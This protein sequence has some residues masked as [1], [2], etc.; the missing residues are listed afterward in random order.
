[1]AFDWQPLSDKQLQVINPDN[2][3]RLNFLDGAVR[4]GKTVAELLAWSAFVSTYAPPGKLA[5]IGKTERTLRRNLLDP[6]LDMFG[7]S[8]VQVNGGEGTALLFGRQVDLYGAN[9][10]KAEGK[11]RGAT[12]AGV[13]CDEV[14]L[15]PEKVF[16]TITSRLSVPGSRLFATLNPDS[17]YHYLYV[18]YL[19]NPKLFGQ[20]RRWRFLLDDNLALSDEFKESIRREHQGLFYDRFV[21]GLWS[22]AEGAIYGSIFNDAL[23]VVDTPAPIHTL[24][25][26]MDYG[27]DNP[28][29][30]LLLG[31]GKDDCIYVLDE[32]YYGTSMDEGRGRPKVQT[33]L[34]HDLRTFLAPYPPVRKGWCDPSAGTFLVLLNRDSALPPIR[35]GYN[36]SVL[37]GIGAVSCLLGNGRLKICRKCVTL[38]KEISSYVWD[39]KASLKGKDMPK[40][41]N[42]HLLDALRYAIVGMRGTWKHWLGAEALTLE[43]AQL[44]GDD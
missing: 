30:F 18:K 37:I 38:L 8:L 32:Y 29:A 43:A 41:T 42:D 19:T 25:L 39:S 40:K 22:L 16:N 13:C 17:P 11:I 20:M 27:M 33:E 3:R 36:R 1:M 34:A 35:K 26:G 6:L 24:Y 7:D 10:E 14:A 28:T 12:W 5:M 21:L 9:D 31:V 44:R 4:S 23:H 15:Y 2:W